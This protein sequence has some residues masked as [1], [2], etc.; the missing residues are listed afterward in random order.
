MITKYSEFILEQLITM[1][2][3]SEVVFSNK[4]RKLLKSID[5]PIANAIV[6]TENK[7]LKVT[8]N[9]L[10]ITDNKDSISFIPDRKVKEVLN[11]DAKKFAT[12]NGSGGILT[13]NMSTNSEIFN[14]LGYEPKTERGYKPEI[15][16][17]GEI[18]SRAVSPGSG[19]TFLY[20]KF[21]NGECV[22]NE[23]RITYDDK[24]K[25][26]WIKNRQTVRVGRAMQALLN[27][28]N[29][30]FKPAD[31]EDFVNKYKSAWEKMNDAFSNFEL[32]EGDDIGYWYNSS[33]YSEYRGTLSNSCMSG[34][35]KNFFQIYMQNRKVCK[36]LIL[37]DDSG[38]KIKGRALVW[39]LE[40][41]EGITF[42]DRIY[43]HHDSDV[44]LFREYSKSQGWYY[45]ARND[46]SDSSNIINPNGD[47]VNL[48]PL[49]VKVFA[50]EYDKYPYVDT[51]KNFNISKG[52]LSTESTGNTYC[53]ED[54]NGGGND[55]EYCG[56]S[57]E[58]ECYECG[59]D[60]KMSCDECDSSGRV[61]CNECDG[62][63]KV[64]CESCDG[65]SEIDCNS[66]DGSGETEDGK[67]G[68]CGGSGKVTCDDCSG[69]GKVNC[70][71]CGGN[72]T[73]DC[74]DCGGTGDKEC[75][76]CGG[77]G[78]VDCSECN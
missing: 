49:V 44:E 67:C 64:N 34:V 30:P 1:V 47:M 63:G 35:P 3:E 45:K 52:T 7:D 55:C 23:Q 31:I 78:M 11:D 28:A 42:M 65:S 14:L 24:L 25:D 26:V 27:A 19:Y 36:L 15:G 53:L 72:G 8:S 22:L 32:V 12:F 71:D 38:E 70:D 77:S 66:C 56:G 21:D 60:G 16:E 68:D 69:E 6:D 40:S 73:V 41:P 13:H 17:R 2:N 9:Y 58:V 5:S 39:K 43:T 75:D 76:Y 50:K 62:E 33:R 57:G 59:G 54:T 48:G 29:Y 74:D 4:L 18:I 46:S 51:L 20:M 61:D 37:K 10:D